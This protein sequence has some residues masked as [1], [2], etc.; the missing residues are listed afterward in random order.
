MTYVTLTAPPIIM[1]EMQFPNNGRGS[2][3]Q[4]QLSTIWLPLARTTPASQWHISSDYIHQC[5]HCAESQSFPQLPAAPTWHCERF[6]LSRHSPKP[7][8]QRA[9]KPKA[10]TIQQPPSYS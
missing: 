6:F 5:W 2:V 9:R 1:Y 10:T 7:K 8:Q 3:M 4:H